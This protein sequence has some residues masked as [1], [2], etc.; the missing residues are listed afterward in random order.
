MN[1]LTYLFLL[2]SRCKL[3]YPRTGGVVCQSH[4]SLS[5]HYLC[6]CPPF[7]AFNFTLPEE[8]RMEMRMKY[9]FPFCKENTPNLKGFLLVRSGIGLLFLIL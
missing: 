9:G 7:L 5:S 1:V 4:R 6:S 3:M 2:E 8:T